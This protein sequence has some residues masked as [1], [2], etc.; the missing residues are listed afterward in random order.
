MSFASRLFANRRSIVSAGV[1][2]LFAAGLVTFALL[3]DGEATADVELNDSGVWVTQTASGQLG[4]FNYEAR[5][6]D[7]VLLAGAASFDV[8]QNAQRVLLDNTGDYSASA[9]NPAH[10]SLGGLMQFPAGAKVAAGG[11][12]TAV[13]DPETGLA[14]VIPFDS[15]AFDE[16]ELK[17]TIKAGKGGK[18]TVGTDGTV[19][20]AVP[21]DHTLYTV[22]TGAQGVAQGVE[23]SSLPLSPTAEVQISAVGDEPVV[24]DQS[25][26]NLI[27]P[28]GK[29]VEVADGAQGMLQQPSDDADNVLIATTKGLVTQPLGGG[30][31]TLWSV[32]GGSSGS[33]SAP[34]QLNGCSY[35]AWSGSG[36]VV[37][38]CAVEGNDFNQVLEGVDASMKLEYRVNRDV[39][40]L[41]D[42]ANGSMWMAPDK[43]QLVDD[44]KVTRPAN[45]KGKKDDSEEAT[46]EQ[47]DHLVADRNK[48]NRPPVPKEDTFG[49]RAGRTTVLNV[50]GNDMD[51]DGDVM[52]ASVKTAPEGDLSVDRVLDGAALQVDVPADAT[53]SVTFQYEVDDGRENGTA[54]AKVRVHVVPDEENNQP[55]QPAEPVLR[56]GQDGLASIKVLPYF[57]DPDGDDLYLTNA[58][59]T[60]PQDEVR[61]RPDGTIEFRDGG[62]TTGRKIVDITVSDSLYL[63]AEG[64][65]LIDV[66]ANNVPPVAVQDHV[67]VLAGQPVTVRPLANDYDA[68]EDELSLVGVPEVPGATIVTNTTAKTLQFQSDEPGSYDVVYRITD[69]PSEP[70]NGLVRVDVREPVEETAPPVAVS[71]QVLLP[72]GGSA[73]VDVLANDTDPAGGVLVVQSV[74]VPSNSPV[75]VSVLNHQI[76]KVSEV[77]RLGGPVTLTYR[78]ANGSTAVTGQVRVVPIPTS[79]QLRPPEAGPDVATVRV[80]DVVTIPVLKNDTHPDGS[81]MHV[82]D[83]LQEAPPASAGEAFV[84]E[85]TVRFR[86]GDEADTVKAVYEV[87][88]A[89]GQKD[90][91]LITIHVLDKPENGAPQLPDVE[92]RVLAEGI[93]RIPL[94][95][96]GTDPDGDYVTL[97]SIASAPSQGTATIV[98]G[99]IDYQAAEGSSGLDSFTYQVIDTRG[100]PGLGTVRVGIAAK[101]ASNQDPQAVDDE[102]TVRPGR[103][104]AIPALENDTDPDGD[105]IGLV[106]KGFEGTEEITPKAVEDNVVVTAPTE[107]KA[108]S[109]YYGIQD[110]YKA[111][112]SGAVTVNVDANAPLLRPIA[113]DDVVTADDVRGAT[114]VTVGVLENDVDPDGVAADLQISVDEGLEGVEVTESGGIKVELAE[115]AR[116]ITYTVTDMDNKEA[117]AFVR[118]PGDESRPHIKPGL[119][120]L[121]AFSGEPLTIDLA[122]YVVVREGREPQITAED[123]VKALEGRAQVPDAGTIIYTS[124]DDYAGAASVS[125]EVT[126]STGADDA[127]ALTSVLTL[128][129]EVTPS[130]NL[131]PKITGTPVLQV[132]AGEQAEVDL[133]RYIKDPDKDP[134][135]IEV[136]GGDGIMTQVS[137]ATV[138]G[139]AEPAIPKGTFVPLPMTVSDGKNPAVETTLTVEVV[140]STRAMAK[141]VPD[142][143]PDAH[144]GE[145]S[146]IPV[147]ANDTNP[148][149]ERSPLRVVDAQR[150]SGQGQVTFD[151]SNV[152]VTPDPDFTGV[153]T[154]RYRVQDATKDPD[155]EVDGTVKLTVLGKPDA[156]RAP[157]VEEVRSGTVVLSWD[158]PNNN[159]ADIT[160]Y[161]LRTDK[162]QEHKCATTTCTFDGL[163]NNVTYTFTVVATNEVDDSEPSPASREARPDEKPDKPAPP[164][165]KFGDST[166]TVSWKNKTYTDRSAIECVNL[167]ISPAPTA[168]PIQ[169]ACETSSPITWTGLEN[170]TAYTVRVQAKNEAETPSDWSDPSA[171]ETP[172]APPAAPAAPTATRVSHFDGGQINVSWN[173][174]ANNGDSIDKYWLGVYTGG[175]LV[176]AIDTTTTSKRVEDLDPGSSYTFKVRGVN[177]AGHGDGSPF[178]NAVEPFGTPAIPGKP[179]ASLNSSNTDGRADVRWA[180]SANFRGTGG[181]YEVLASNGDVKNAGGDLF[182]TMTGL[183]NGTA[184]TF[185]VRACNSGA[186]SD[187]TDFSNAVTPYGRPHEPDITATG[188]YNQVTFSWNAGPENGR[189]NTIDVYGAVESAAVSGTDQD[190]ANPGESKTACIKVT[191]AGGTS[192]KC[193]T[194]S[195]LN[196]RVWLTEGGDASC[197]RCKYWVVNW[198]GFDTGNHEVACWAGDTSR[199][200]GPREWHD[201]HEPH[202]ESWGGSDRYPM[203]G[204]AGRRQL[205]CY[206]GSQY[207]GLEVGFMAGTDASH[208][209]YGVTTWNS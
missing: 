71:D 22:K 101:P 76:L 10:L 95:L 154:V 120:P 4:R 193:V 35:G 73:L 199:E 48:V 167:E 139:E 175:E 115:K 177:K 67:S 25:T 153:M 109:F 128:P 132:A 114:S 179:T 57:K 12:T 30:Q 130:K 5:A 142:V 138:T 121:K 152:I 44:W 145:A 136:T 105:Q 81:A 61:F 91:A 99:F 184:Y 17:P 108:Y 168:G 118:A 100:A 3:Y 176:R 45:G 83:E 122:K 111:D 104:V 34:V 169:K 49:V 160:S 86:A 59:T 117:K 32:D 8:E 97:S 171:P 197:A 72:A 113:H 119:D 186:C 191:S 47:V 36:R 13:Y 151:E 15:A 205:S 63:P 89:N 33:V 56:V 66:V 107:E 156:P 84:S 157:R 1:V 51:P 202:A 112:A 200:G 134:L 182:T 137:G 55:E 106:A 23:E 60:D 148:F 46:P 93:V 37:R 208:K 27:L 178:S 42:V 64:R 26:G 140:R 74:D 180:K 21:Q 54:T 187:Y 188:G 165:L 58:S 18:L 102:T 75:N 62:T 206:M 6:L 189:P 181:Y 204:A 124:A 198:E 164:T 29:S 14:W 149:P 207:N 126:D 190:A 2:T 173:E 50:L 41:N 88:D 39:I 143:V 159:G 201:I 174:P 103:T 161:T 70:V 163:Q 9:V 31:S 11:A 141:T 78:V 43:F 94:P 20:L 79:E 147:L 68:N 38:N 183:S 65:L 192:E 209:L 166:L 110:T 85:D 162:G 19:Y 96:D 40:V 172:A 196:P 194:A 185:Q 87:E 129:I 52:T 127:E 146:T 69:G 82:T 158:Q 7:G 116:V 135:T 131:P 98:D 80:G 144:Q 24:L 150:D 125:F 155:R 133:S 77:K 28:G 16:K 203:N 92:A 170:G 123:T 90:S 195:A 53:G